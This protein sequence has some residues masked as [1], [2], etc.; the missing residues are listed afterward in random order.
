MASELQAQKEKAD[1]LWAR[2]IRAK[3]PKCYRPDCD[4]ATEEACHTVPRA[5]W[6]T[7]WDLRNG[8]GGCSFH[9]SD[10]PNCKKL[11]EKIKAA[12]I[13][14]SLYGFLHIQANDD[15]T[16]NNEDMDHIIQ[17]FEHE[18]KAAGIKTY[19]PKVGEQ[20][21]KKAK[22]QR[23]LYM[24]NYRNL[25][26]GLSPAQVQYRTMKAIKKASKSK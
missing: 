6:P 16:P 13:G 5:K 10:E 15:W 21:R 24:Q 22:E 3:Y 19:T 1:F 20:R 7:R 4:K 14:L 17:G 12:I 26:N 2:L 23:K 8:L 25:H 9:N 11:T 18:C